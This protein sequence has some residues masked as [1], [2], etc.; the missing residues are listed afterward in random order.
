MNQETSNSHMVILRVM[1]TL[2]AS[3]FWYSEYEL[4]Q[5]NVQKDNTKITI[6]LKCPKITH[7]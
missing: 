2:R 6:I 4:A 1:A 7:Q 3:G 5:T